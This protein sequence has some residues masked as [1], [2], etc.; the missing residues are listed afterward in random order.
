MPARPAML[1]IAFTFLL[2]EARPVHGAPAQ[3]L[4]ARAVAGLIN[5]KH[6][7][8]LNARQP[9]G[10][11]PAKRYGNSSTVAVAAPQD[12]VIGAFEDG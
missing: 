11:R 1:S 12:A 3:M 9:I 7:F 5:D 2:E 4:L 6:A 8:G 10:A